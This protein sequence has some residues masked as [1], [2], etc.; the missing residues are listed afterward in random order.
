MVPGEAGGGF[1]QDKRLG[2]LRHVQTAQRAAWKAAYNEPQPALSGQ[3]GPEG[4]HGAAAAAAARRSSIP[5]RAG[6]RSLRSL[7]LRDFEVE[8]RSRGGGEAER[9]LHQLKGLAERGACGAVESGVC[10]S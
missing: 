4:L 8:C 6:R 10:T 7:K 2:P 1:V 5:S 3:R 9:G